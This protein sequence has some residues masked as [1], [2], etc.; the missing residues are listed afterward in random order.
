[1]SLKC[2]VS[3]LVLQFRKTEAYSNFSPGKQA[4]LIQMLNKY[5]KPLYNLIYQYKYIFWMY[6]FHFRNVYIWC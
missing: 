1:M 2:L 5:K 4:T 6:T 3:S